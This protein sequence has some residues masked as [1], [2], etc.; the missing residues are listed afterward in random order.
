MQNFLS[1]RELN[2]ICVPVT[3]RHTET[4]KGEREEEKFHGNVRSCLSEERTFSRQAHHQFMLAYHH[5]IMPSFT[6]ASQLNP[7]LRQAAEL[8]RQSKAF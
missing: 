1:G 6:L 8:S 7:A 5:V 3:K 4:C 2:T